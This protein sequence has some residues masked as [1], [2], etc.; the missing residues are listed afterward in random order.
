MRRARSRATASSRCSRTRTRPTLSRGRR[1]GARRA[2]VAA[3]RV[4]RADR[5]RRG[6]RRRSRPRARPPSWSRSST[7][8][9]RH[10]VDA[11]RDHPGALPP[12]QVNAGYPTDT[13]HGDV[14]AGARGGA[15]C[16]IDAT[17][18]TPAEHNNPMEP[19]ARSRAGRA[20]SSW[21]TTPTRAL[22]RA[23][24]ALA[25]VFGLEPEQVRVI[26]ADTSARIR[27]S[28]AGART[29]ARPARGASTRPDWSRGR[30]ARR[31]PSARA[32]GVHHRV[33]VDG[34]GPV[35]RV[36]PDGVAGQ[37][38]LE[39]AVAGVRGKAGVDLG[40]REM[41]GW[42]SR[43]ITSWRSAATSTRTRYAAARASSRLSATTAATIWPR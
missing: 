6:R 4:P 19:H 21:S 23:A 24:G 35:R 27:T 42:S 38:G 39:V 2:A 26:L 31:P 3:G 18:T 14:D 32:W 9:S 8:P 11:A 40:R 10:D 25:Q 28:P 16:A 17:Y 22:G 15:A 34:R 12:E 1:R 13:R 33:V 41:P 30:S 7:R 5:R 37:A 43:R 20:A 36:D 29:P